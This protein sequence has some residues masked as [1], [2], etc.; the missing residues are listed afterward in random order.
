VA[1]LSG[2]LFADVIIKKKIESECYI[3]WKNIVGLGRVLR[4]GA[5]GWGLLREGKN[6]AVTWRLEGRNSCFG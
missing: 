3:I 1:F 2:P 6:V 4:C 5:T